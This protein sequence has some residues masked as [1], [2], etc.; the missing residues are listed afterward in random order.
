MLFVN[1]HAMVII[2]CVF[3][4]GMTSG[5]AGQKLPALNAGN[6]LQPELAPQILRRS[7]EPRQPHVLT[8]TLAPEEIDRA[9]L[10][11]LM[12]EIVQEPEITAQR[13]GVGQQT[14]QNIFVAISNARN[15]INGNEM[16]SVRAM[17]RAWDN[18]E[19]RGDARIQE[20][21][22]AYSRRHQ[23]TKD[24]VARYYR[25]LLADIEAILPLTAQSRFE[26]YMTDRRQRMAS[27]G[28][29][30]M[31]AV[32]QNVESGRESIEFHCRG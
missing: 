28:A 19:L 25:V 5:V 8:P 12:Q 6:G 30:T 7:E 16:A 31:G 13:L 29:V 11:R 32:V 1:K 9:V 20:A 3:T 17:C 27:S 18:S 22:D 4:A 10:N 24:F 23:F 15:F 21:L 2:A 14:L 26:S